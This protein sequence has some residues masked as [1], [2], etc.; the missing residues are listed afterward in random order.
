MD[1]SLA[2]PELETGVA[3]VDAARRITAWSPSAARLTGRAIDD[4]VGGEVWL[5]LPA[6]QRRVADETF[7][8]VLHDGVARTL[9]VSSRASER[10]D[11][12]LELEVSRV[13]DHLLCL[14]RNA[15]PPVP[16]VAE[17]P[18]SY[19]PSPDR[20]AL[21]GPEAPLGAL[22]TGVAYELRGR[23]D[24]ITAFATSLRDEARI[25]AVAEQADVIHTEAAGAT[26]DVGALLTF[27]RS[28]APA[29]RSVD[30]QEVI[31]QV[32]AL[33]RGALRTGR[34]ATTVTLGANLPRPWADPAMLQQLLLHAVVGAERAI[35]VIQA[36]GRIAL[37]A[38]LS[39]GRVLVV[40]EDNGPEIPG[41]ALGRPFDPFV[42]TRFGPGTDIGLAVSFG[43]I[44]T[45][46]GRMWMLNV[47]G[48]GVRHCF[49]LPV[50]PPGGRPPARRLAVLVVDGHA[51]RRR[52]TQVLAERLGHAVTV[53]AGAPEAL[54]ALRLPGA[55][56]EA[57]LLDVELGASHAGLELLGTLTQ[58]GR[59]YDHNV[60]LT[61][62][63]VIT[64]EAC[65]RL[66]AT[67]RP[68][69]HVPCALGELRDLLGRV[70]SVQA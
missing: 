42:M 44:R 40:L 45:L 34:I 16:A 43:L 15:P 67:D 7:E 28:P 60:I 54:E 4:V 36:P 21:S 19:P 3:V 1:Q 38:R 69:L 13:D 8:E 39:G 56:Y 47:A 62:G 20:V 5:A 57:V 61:T 66:D 58:E 14:I 70:P 51:P 52:A 55:A 65:V 11:S 18:G 59:G 10:G 63:D 32:L 30:L 41:D 25:P 24:A 53:A 22:V 29:P 68:V 2:D 23:L 48:G 26:R 31:D 17:H 6:L 27:S 9:V 50:E 49:E 12:P 64:P 33:R 35:A 46:G 37:S